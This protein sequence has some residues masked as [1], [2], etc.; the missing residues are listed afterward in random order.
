MAP[1]WWWRTPIKV[2]QVWLQMRGPC[3]AG[4]SHSSRRWIRK[5]TNVCWRPLRKRKNCLLK[6]RES[7]A[8]FPQRTSISRNARAERLKNISTASGCHRAGSS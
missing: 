3:R 2:L 5:T 6:P 4:Q 1:R 8:S 7:C